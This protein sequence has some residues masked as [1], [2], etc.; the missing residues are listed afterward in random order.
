MVISSSEQLRPRKRKRII[1]SCTECHRRKQKCDRQYPCCNCIKREKQ[2]ICYYDVDPKGCQSMPSNCNE[3]GSSE[4]SNSINTVHLPPPTSLDSE[5]VSGFQD[6]IRDFGY[7]SQGNHHSMSLLRTTELYGAQS[8][9]LVSP[10]IT[11]QPPFQSDTNFKYKEL[12]RQLPS[13]ACIDILVE[14]FFSDINWQYALLDER[15]VREQLEKWRKVSYSDLQKG[16]ERLTSETLVFPALLLQ[17]IAQALLFHPP[18]DERISS[19][20][21]MAGMSFHDLGAEYSDTGAKILEI[22]GKR[23]ITIATVQSGLLRA[24]FLK[25]SGKVV[26]AWHVLGATIRDAQEIGLHTGRVVSE[27]SPIGPCTDGHRI[28]VIL[29][30]WDIHMAVVL[31]RPATTNLQIDSFSRTIE[32]DG[33]RQELFSHWQTE[34]DPPRPFDIILAG[35]N[36]AYRYFQDIHQLEYNGVKLQDYPKVE[37]IHAAIQKN[38]ELLPSWCRLENPDTKF[39][40]IRGCQWLRVA[41]EGLYSLINLVLLTLHR[42]YIFSVANSQMEALKAG[43]S[44]LRTQ[45]RLFQQSEPHQCKVFNPV[46]ASFDALV[47]IAAIYV[48]FPNQNQKWRAESVQVVERGMER[49]RIIGLCNYMAKSAYGVVWNLYY[50]LKHRLDIL[51]TAEDFETPHSNPNWISPNSQKNFSN[52]TPL[53][54][55]FDTVIPPRP[56]HD[57]FYDHISSTQIPFMDTPDNLSLDPLNT[58]I[59]NDWNFEGDFSNDS[60]WSLMNELIN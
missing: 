33:R 49:L 43:I 15:T 30:I 21:T 23:D 17:V 22:L 53:E 34:T 39:D 41:R 45:E 54:P 60:F 29:H 59:T 48:A 12:V 4:S 18:H 14:T 1:I 31:G 5:W 40:Q 9:F 58:N 36:V 8:A 16:L 25:S 24:S 47:L 7:S 2:D 28:W 3:S 55:S 35:Y 20:I 57:L 32:D 11:N 38:L 13:K 44:I 50:H 19:L 56:S 6:E 10:S 42:P 46:Y 27:R 37:S 51:E 26:E 52:G